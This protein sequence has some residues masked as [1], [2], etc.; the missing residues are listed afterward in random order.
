MEDNVRYA[1]YARKELEQ[2]GYGDA[3]IFLN[4]WNP[5]IA[6][7]GRLRDAAN[8]AAGMRAMQPPTDMCMYY[9][10]QIA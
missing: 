6:E 5:G 9:D 10:A 2:Y 4:E 1:A 3:E 7:K 8:I